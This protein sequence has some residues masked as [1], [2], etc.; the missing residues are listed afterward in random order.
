MIRQPEC[1]SPKMIIIS[2]SGIAVSNH[3]TP[4]DVQILFADLHYGDL[5]YVVTGQKHKG[6]IG[7][8]LFSLN[9]RIFGYSGLVEKMVSRLCRA[10]WFERGNTKERMEFLTDVINIARV[11]KIS[12]I[13]MKISFFL[14]EVQSFQ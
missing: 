10:L 5:Q 7:I 13:T 1:Y 12:S 6:V 4:N 14:Y 8:D 2:I 9:I 3:L 11:G